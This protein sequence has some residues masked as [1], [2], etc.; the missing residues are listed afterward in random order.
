MAPS[1]CGNIVKSKRTLLALGWS[2]VNLLTF[3]SFL[4]CLL[5]VL[6]SAARTFQK[7]QQQQQQ[8]GY[9][10][11][12]DN[13]D[14][15]DNLRLPFITSRAMAFTAL[16]I[17]ALSA[18]L[19]MYGTMVLGF[20]S[21]LTARYYWCCAHTV[22]K[23]TPMILGAFIGSLL[24]YA[25]LTLVCSVLFGEFQ[26]RDWGDNGEGG[27]REGE[28]GG[29]ERDRQRAIKRENMSKSSTAFSILCIFVTILY[30]GFAALVFVYSD[31]LMEENQQ[32]LRREAL[33]PS[34][35]DLEDYDDDD[36]RPNREMRDGRR[37]LIGNR[38]T[39]QS[40]GSAV[41]VSDAF[42]RSTDS[43]SFGAML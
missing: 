42:I 37:G 13:N 1:I 24:M 20:V 31:A 38:F 2:L 41:G 29:G 34:S 26:V 11:Y 12:P 22:H 40:P 15:R 7:Q 9:Y 10:Y 35:D 39:V 16:W 3:L 23:T 8:Q 21:P 14:N 27:E 43:G 5:Y 32:D 18:I 30:A 25:N 4:S 6:L 28:G 19:G 17:M 33:R 36:D